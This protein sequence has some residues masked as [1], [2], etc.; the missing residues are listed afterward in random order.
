MEKKFEQPKIIDFQE[1]FLTYTFLEQS[2][3]QK[4]TEELLYNQPCLHTH[5]HTHTNAQDHTNAHKQ[6]HT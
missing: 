4:L 2:I 6:M 5:T 1:S 3:S